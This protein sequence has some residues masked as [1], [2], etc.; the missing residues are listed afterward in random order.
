[1]ATSFDVRNPDFFTLVPP[2]AEL[3]CVAGGFKFT[4]GPV[5]RDGYLLFNDIPNNRTVCWQE[6]SGRPFRFHLSHAIRQRERPYT[7]SRRVVSSPANT[8]RAA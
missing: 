1:M 2:D 4:E 7:G 8:P 6:S 5:W 3:E